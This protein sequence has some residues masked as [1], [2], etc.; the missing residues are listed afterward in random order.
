MAGGDADYAKVHFMVM[1]LIWVG[2]CLV[3]VVPIR[4]YR[5]WVERREWHQRVNGVGG[6]P[7]ETWADLGRAE[8]RD[9]YVAG[10]GPPSEG[11]LDLRPPRRNQG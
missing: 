8:L 1:L 5:Q 10:A 4:V 9:N 2:V 7:A 3:I 11:W 6:L